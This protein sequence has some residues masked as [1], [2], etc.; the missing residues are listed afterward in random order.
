MMYVKITNAPHL[1][2]DFDKN[3]KDTQQLLIPHIIYVIE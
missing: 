3:S 2:K 1:W